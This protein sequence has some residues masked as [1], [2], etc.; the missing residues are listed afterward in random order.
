MTKVTLH[1]RTLIGMKWYLLVVL[2]FTFPHS[3]CILIY[4]FAGNRGAKQPIQLFV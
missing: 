2:I 1:A 3:L 4:S